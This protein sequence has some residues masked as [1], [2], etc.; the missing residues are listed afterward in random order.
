MSRG[1][2]F[3]ELGTIEVIFQIKSTIQIPDTNFDDETT[4]VISVFPPI[5]YYLNS[6]MHDM[7][8]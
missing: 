3:V 6:M 5:S 4:D 8:Y 1:F 2:A 7:Q